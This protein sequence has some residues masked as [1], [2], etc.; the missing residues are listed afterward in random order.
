MG[1]VCGVWCGCAGTAAKPHLVAQQRREERERREALERER[2]A[3]IKAEVGGV[4]STS[5]CSALA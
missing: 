5:V 1:V 3:Q 2:Q 4:T